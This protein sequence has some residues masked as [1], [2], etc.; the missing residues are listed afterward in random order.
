VPHLVDNI[1][2]P[3]NVRLYIHQQWTTDKVVVSQVWPVG[4]GTVNGHPIPPGYSNVTIDNI[5]DKEYNKIHIDY[6][7]QEDRSKLR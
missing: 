4:D 5:L 7:A 6:P 3:V 2:E 1:T